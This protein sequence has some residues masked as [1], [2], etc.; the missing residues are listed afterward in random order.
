MKARIYK[1]FKKYF[2]GKTHINEEETMN[3]EELANMNFEHCLGQPMLD[4]NKK[5]MK[6][7]FYDSKWEFPR[8]R[9]DIGELV[10]EGEFG[11]VLRARADGIHGHDGNYNNIL[12]C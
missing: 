7:P 9:L 5:P 8:H 4:S 3:K 11:M 2:R 12:F 10:G 1:L 6:P